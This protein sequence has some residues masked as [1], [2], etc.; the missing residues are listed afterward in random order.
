[1]ERISAD[2]DWRAMPAFVPL[3]MGPKHSGGEG[4][5]VC[6][7]GGGK[8]SARCSPARLSLGM[9]MSTTERQVD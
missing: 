7:W 3:K 9:D 4:V 8:I 6:V 1:M 5:S 2:P